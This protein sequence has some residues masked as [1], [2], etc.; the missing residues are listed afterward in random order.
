MDGHFEDSSFVT[1]QPGCMSCGEQLWKQPS[2]SM[3]GRHK[4]NKGCRTGHGCHKERQD[5][6]KGGEANRQPKKTAIQYI[7]L[8]VIAQM[9]AC[10]LFDFGEGK[11][12]LILPSGFSSVYQNAGLFS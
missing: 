8:D 9:L 2:C 4:T 10:E 6:A 7:D 1:A 3:N 11:H 12:H 5:R